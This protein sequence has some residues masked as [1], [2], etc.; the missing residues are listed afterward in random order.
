MCCLA[1]RRYL[2]PIN[3]ACRHGA[4]SD[5]IHVSAKQLFR[6]DQPGQIHERSRLVGAVADRG[7]VVKRHILKGFAK[8][9]QRGQRPI[10]ARIRDFAA[11]AFVA[12][13][14]AADEICEEDDE[15][16][17]IRPLAKMDMVNVKSTI[18]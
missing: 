9:R 7:L 3:Q 15:H 6:A 10:G 16:L 14:R 17:R 4:R 5:A 18:W 13:R 12:A 11:F 8:W 1:W 2:D